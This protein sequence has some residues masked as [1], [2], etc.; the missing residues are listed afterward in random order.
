MVD[1]GNCLPGTGQYSVHYAVVLCSLSRFPNSIL[2]RRETKKATKITAAQGSG[3][4]W[5]YEVYWGVSGLP[6][7]NKGCEP[8]ARD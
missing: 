1:R 6:G 3:T 5:G 2:R 4:G 7:S 8:R